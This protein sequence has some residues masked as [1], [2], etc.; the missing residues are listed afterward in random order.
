MLCPH[1][2]HMSFSRVCSYCGGEHEALSDRIRRRQGWKKLLVRPT[3]TAGVLALVFLL[4]GGGVPG[5][6]AGVILGALLGAVFQSLC[7]VKRYR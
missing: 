3:I 5:L 6:M 4:L 1:C 7:R 2:L